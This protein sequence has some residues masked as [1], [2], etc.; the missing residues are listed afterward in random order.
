[1]LW[2]VSGWYARGY[3]AKTPAPPLLLV[4]SAGDGANFTL[5]LAGDIPTFYAA[6]A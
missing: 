3:L 5:I 2:L 4:L 1:V 6:F